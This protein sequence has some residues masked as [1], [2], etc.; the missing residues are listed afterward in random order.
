M[1]TIY[2]S[3]VFI[4]TQTGI[5]LPIPS[6][7]PSRPSTYGAMSSYDTRR[8]KPK[9]P[10]LAVIVMNSTYSCD[11][12][13]TIIPS[14][15]Q[16]RIPIVYCIDFSIGSPNIIMEIRS[17]ARLIVVIPERTSVSIDIF[18]SS[19]SQKSQIQVKKKQLNYSA[20]YRLTLIP[21]SL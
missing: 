20:I 19:C 1:D 18:I 17:P 8:I 11:C 16:Y 4:Y 10:V 6:I 7:D 21:S 9:P 5:H 12:T 13:L 14:I 3:N 2:C 15:V